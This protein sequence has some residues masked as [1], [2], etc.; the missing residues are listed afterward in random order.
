VLGTLVF[1]RYNTRMRKWKRRSLLALGAVAGVGAALFGGG[2]H[3]VSRRRSER[4][5]VFY[6]L[7]GGWDLM[8]V[9]DP[10]LQRRKGQLVPFDDDDV[11]VAG[12]ERFGPA[13]APLRPFFSQ[14]AVVRGLHVDALNHPQARHRMVTGR[15]WTP[16]TPEATSVQTHLAEALGQGYALPNLSGNQL[17]PIVFAG[18][19]DA[20]L[21]PLRVSSVDELA[22]LTDVEGGAASD[23]VS[24]ALARRDARF[25][26]RNSGAPVAAASASRAALQR[27]IASSDFPARLEMAERSSGLFPH[28]R[29]LRQV[30]LALEAIRQD[31]APVVTIGTGEFDAHTGDDYAFHRRAVT[32]GL[33]AVAALAHGLRNSRLDDGSTLLDRTTIVVTS[34]FSRA[35]QRNELGGKHHWS[36]NSMLLVGGGVRGGND[37][38]PRVVG[39]V[40][41][42]LR[43]LPVDPQTGRPARSGELLEMSHA[44]A[45]VMA[46]VGVDPNGRFD[47]DPIGGIVA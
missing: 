3:V 33:D 25:V 47:A 11:V 28:G 21:E 9:S 18:D 24:A 16:G 8:L 45:T 35:P 39:A 10:P 2:G 14:M 20:R 41:S 32:G 29:A 44:L 6:F 5:V 13:M 12:D 7:L 42:G 36:T 38:C 22:R 43:A 1:R 34:E 23:A 27:M 17:R 37:V 19:D 40:D 15:F 26:E 4:A 30:D 31:L 46:A